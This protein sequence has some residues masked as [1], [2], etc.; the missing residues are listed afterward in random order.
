L[1][2]GNGPPTGEPI[3]SGST[4]PGKTPTPSPPLIQVGPG[5]VTFGTRADSDRR[6]LDPKTSF[7]TDERIVWSAHLVDP[8][9]SVEVRILVVKED[10]V[11][12][13]GERLIADDGISPPVTDAELF[14]RRVRPSRYLDGPGYYTVRYVRGD[15]LMA[16][17][18]FVITE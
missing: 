11:A 6:I 5:F 2:T 4:S 1:P 17:G 10:P 15:R 12:P 8:V 14:V 16:E 3:A 7:T 18:Y 13:G 9:D